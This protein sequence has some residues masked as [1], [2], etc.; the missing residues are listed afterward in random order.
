MP[1]HTPRA[2][3]YGTNGDDRLA[4]LGN[5]GVVPG[6]GGHD[7]LTRDYNHAT[8]WGE[9]GNDR[10]TLRL[11]FIRQLGPN[12]AEQGARAFGGNDDDP[13]LLRVATKYGA[14]DFTLDFGGGRPGTTGSRST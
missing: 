6:L 13:I 9:A 12:P 2:I 7:V 4:T 11:R 5:G 1:T 8:L 3:R 10:L 14:D